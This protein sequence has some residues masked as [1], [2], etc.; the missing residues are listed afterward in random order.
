MSSNDA[1]DAGR[2]AEFKGSV[3]Q[4]W[5]EGARAWRKWNSKLGV[6][7]RGA[8]EA[9]V[10]TAQVGSG[11]RVLDLASG[12][13]EPALSLAEA[14][15]PDGH[16]TA[17]DL[18]PDM[19]AVAEEDAGQ[20]GLRNITFR[21]ADAEALPFADASFDRVTCRFGVM[22]FPDVAVALREIHRVLKPG[23][24]AA[25]VAWGPLQK[26]PYFT[27]TI[28]V[29]MKYVQLPP[30]E[31][32]APNP[33]R[34]AQAAALAGALTRA[35]FRDVQAEERSIPWSWPGPAEEALQSAQ[36]LAAPGFRRLRE[37]LP[38]ERHT[39]V[40]HEMLEAVRSHSSGDQ[41]N[42]TA[43]IVEATGER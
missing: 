7:S 21:Q 16:V 5:T 10:R 33:F 15:G 39:Q 37:A 19:L 27:A 26:N 42:F 1:P 11:M 9:I 14:V 23:G 24:R 18:V 2:L 17:T 12:T 32:G 20:R 25:F 4:D 28:G 40:Q 3:R 41:V 30:P 29:F 43:T 13:G 34:F 38:P 35:S 36:E 31:P 6:V 8:T 22:F